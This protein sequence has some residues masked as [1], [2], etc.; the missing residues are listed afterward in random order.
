MTVG[1]GG[2]EGV[3]CVAYD[4]VG[5]AP[6]LPLVERLVEGDRRSEGAPHAHDAIRLPLAHVA[7][8]SGRVTERGLAERERERETGKKGGRYGGW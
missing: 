1:G 4:E 8:E 2:V 7:V 3:A 5:D 6:N